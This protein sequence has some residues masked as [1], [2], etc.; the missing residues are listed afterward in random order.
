MN[1]HQRA[2]S[3]RGA[4]AG[5]LA[6][7]AGRGRTAVALFHGF[8]SGPVSVAGWAR[9]LAAAGADVEVPLLP[10]HGT[11][12]RDLAA[13]PASA[14]RTAARDTVDGLLAGHDRVVA[15]GLSMGGALA[16]DAAAHR[17]VA[18]TVVV[19]PGLRFASAAAPLAGILKHVIRSV[20]PI[21]DD[22][23]RPGVTEQAY[24]R[25]P[26][27]AVQQVGALQAAVRAG[28]HAVRTPVLAFRSTTD[29][30]VPHSSMDVLGRRLPPGLLTVRP[31]YNS[32]HV[33]TLDWDAG[34]IEQE[35]VRFIA[36]LPSGRDVVADRS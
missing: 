31:L 36:A 25:T 2:L 3:L 5:P 33:A 13:V 34:I 7:T 32:R 4:D 21:A 10:G 14:W 27:A 22:L 28:L 16:L 9:A 11:H 23:V 15:A 8:T 35:S 19:N 20:T 18:G 29:H 6:A 24:P 30:V 1:A 26:V 17:P 12:W